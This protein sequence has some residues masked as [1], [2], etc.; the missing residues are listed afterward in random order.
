MN[1]IKPKLQFKV[2]FI[3]G[4][5]LLSYIY[6][7][8]IFKSYE[9]RRFSLL[10]RERLIEYE[11]VMENLLEL[12]G[13]S[14]HNAVKQLQNSQEKIAAFIQE[15]EISF[16]EDLL[17]LYIQDQGYDALWVLDTTYQTV[18][19]VNSLSDEMNELPIPDRERSVALNNKFGD[20]FF[21]NS[22]QGL[23]E[24]RGAPLSFDRDS[25]TSLA[26][27]IFLA[28]MWDDSFV[29]EMNKLTSGQ[30]VLYKFPNSQ[31]L[32]L[33]PNKDKV[34]VKRALYDW[35]DIEVAHLEYIGMELNNREFNAFATNL[36]LL[37]L[38]ISIVIFITITLLLIKWIYNPI[39]LISN[40]IRY[41][42]TY[43]LEK[44]MN[45][46]NE[47]GQLS[48]LT[49]D[50]IKQKENLVREIKNKVRNEK[51]LK[52]SEEKF[53]ELINQMP[54]YI[55]VH[56]DGKIIYVNEAS[57][58]KLGFEKE[59]VIDSPLLNYI[60][61]NDRAKVAEEI[62]TD[63]QEHEFKDFEMSI[64][65]AYGELHPVI[66]R[67]S[68]I[69]YEENPAIMSVLIDISERKRFEKE[70]IESSAGLKAI[71]D[72]LPYS[73]WLKDRNGRFVA[74]NRTFA[75]FY[76]MSP[77]EIKGKTDF[78]LCAPEVALQYDELDKKVIESK[79]RIY[80]EWKNPEVKEGQWIETF[81]FPIINGKG[82]VIG[83]TGIARD[84]TDTKKK[85]LELINA[86]EYADAANLAKQQFLSMMSHEVRNQLNAIIGLSQLLLVESPK[87]EQRE[88]LS[89]LNFSAEHLLGLINDMLDF[90]KI[91]AGKIDFV[92]SE[93]NI[94]EM[95]INLRNSFTIKAEEKGISLESSVD[96]MLP[97][98]LIGDQTRLSQILTNL[99][100]NAVK[101]TTK[102]KVTL[103]VKVLKV[104]Q[105]RTKIE[106]R[107]SDTGVGIEPEQQQAIFDPFVQTKQAAN[108]GGT[109]LGLSI[110]KKLI[111]LQKGEIQLESEFGK[112][113]EFIFI[114][115]YRTPK[116]QKDS[117]QELEKGD[118][119]QKFKDIRILLVEDN[120]INKLIASRYL[121]KWGALV[122]TADNGLIALE[123]LAKSSYDLILM[124]LQMPEMDGFEATKKIRDNVNLEIKNIP[125]IAL[126]ASAMVEVREEVIEAGMNDFITKPFNPAELNNIIAKYL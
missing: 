24:F 114:L 67:S 105:G 37:Y 71:L 90:S 31:K 39:K 78:D 20:H 82:E 87:P 95:I 14:F 36:F 117:K 1:R 52:I 113:S 108:K 58:S 109:G 120:H 76:N 19:A 46:N 60:S 81:K 25:I 34:S 98:I 79:K 16:A 51:T 116:S 75:S 118:T 15:P 72:N 38:F 93:F 45:K 124:D 86:K 29:S 121:E 97:E 44:I 122:D 32:Q 59:K 107:V 74:I 54:D 47:F 2:L 43:P 77:D 85:Q 13:N 61:K 99:I 73:A 3:I 28:R 57:Y 6:G 62:R 80:F 103:K 10:Q 50:F 17:D 48:K 42:D 41:N 88:N 5:L 53:R 12:K 123:Q 27:Y 68:I 111:E 101:F 33:A 70:L 125:I 9:E 83:T 63:K 89:T 65:D 110:T 102:G 40:S 96:M 4:I 112:G 55:V 18:Y 8:F 66:V 11:D 64:V 104:M 119:L 100:G 26:G 49:L 69:T 94:R 35:L 30:V 21:Y 56:H 106:F 7:F 22:E 84:I 115:E 126:T 92:E 91:E 23:M